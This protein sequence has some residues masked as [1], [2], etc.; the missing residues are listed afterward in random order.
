MS[1]RRVDDTNFSRS[2]GLTL[3]EELRAVPQTGCGEIIYCGE[4]KS[5]V[6]NHPDAIRGHRARI[7]KE[8]WL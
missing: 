3:T 2:E 7:H 5:P 1:S 4:C 6:V 8:V